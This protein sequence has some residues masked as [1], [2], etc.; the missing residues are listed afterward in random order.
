MQT[1]S[2][3]VYLGSILYITYLNCHHL[4]YLLMCTKVQDYRQ[5]SFEGEEQ[6]KAERDIMWALSDESI[7]SLI[8][9]SIQNLEIVHLCINDTVYRE[10]LICFC[11]LD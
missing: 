10:I 7:C 1:P 3:H 4:W 11:N 2:N 5:F 6:S 8:P 9:I